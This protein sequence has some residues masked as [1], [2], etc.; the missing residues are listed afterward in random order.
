MI[1]ALD[2][3]PQIR[4][5]LF[6]KDGTL[7][8]FDRTWSRINLAAARHGARGDTAVAEHFLRLGGQDPVTGRTAA[9]SLF[10]AGNAVEIAEAW[11]AAGAA[12]DHTTLARDL[13]RIFAEGMTEAVPLPGVPEVFAQLSGMDLLLG[14]ASSDSEASVRVFVEGLGAASSF[15]FLCGYDSGHGPKPEPGMVQGFA[16]ATGLTA[17]SIAMVGDNTH[18]LEMARRAGAGLAI[19]V[20]SGTGTRA[21]LAPLADLILDS[22]AELPAFFVGTSTAAPVLASPAPSPT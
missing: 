14:V 20:L 19:G 1:Q 22:V 2:V 17:D 12:F 15:R 21:D 3:P 4:A 9:G 16:A 18:D 5:I 13:D 7:L 10:A 6:D 11:V 8:D